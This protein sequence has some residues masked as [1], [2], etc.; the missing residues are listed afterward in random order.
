M[1]F[2]IFLSKRCKLL[3]EQ[4]YGT[5]LVWISW[6]SPTVGHSWLIDE[7]VFKSLREEKPYLSHC[8]W[9][10]ISYVSSNPPRADSWD[11]PLQN[12]KY[13]WYLGA[14]ISGSIPATLCQEILVISY[15]KMSID[16]LGQWH[17]FIP[18]SVYEHLF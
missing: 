12:W 5:Y 13:Y 15:C 3:K 11:F 2:S 8:Q 16:S 10:V 17:L 18:F 1:Y 7:F 14:L 4:V 9:R 6:A